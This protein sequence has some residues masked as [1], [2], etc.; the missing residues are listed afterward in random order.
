MTYSA[1]SPI[2]ESSLNCI[3]R[4]GKSLQQLSAWQYFR[5]QIVEEQSL[6]LHLTSLSTGWEKDH[7]SYRLECA[8]VCQ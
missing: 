5:L 8:V 4:V 2:R 6:S 1:I 7:M 3:P